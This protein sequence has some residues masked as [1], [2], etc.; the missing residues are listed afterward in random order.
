MKLFKSLFNGFRRKTLNVIVGVIVSEYY[1]SQ[2]VSYEVRDDAFHLPRTVA[3]E[4]T[5]LN[6]VMIMR[7]HI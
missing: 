7:L 4:E 5:F 6:P 2:S 1:G 3:L